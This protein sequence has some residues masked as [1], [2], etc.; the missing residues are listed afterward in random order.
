MRADLAAQPAAVRTNLRYLWVGNIPEKERAEFVAVLNGH[1]N[2]LS[3][4]IDLVPLTTVGRELLRVNLEDYAWDNS[5]WEK[6][7]DADPYYHT[8]IETEVITLWPGGVWPKDG[9][10]Y[11]AG[12]FRES[13]KVVT[14]AIAPWAGDTKA[15]AEVVNWTGSKVPVVRAD[16]FLA[17]TAIQ[18]GRAVGYYDFLGVKDQKGFEKLVGFD[19][20]LAKKREQRK[21]LVFSGITIQPRRVE[22]T[23]S[24]D[25]G[26]WRTFDSAKAV[27]KKNPLRILDD[28]GFE[29]DVTEQFAPLPNGLM[30]SYLGDSKGNRQDKAPDNIVQIPRLHVNLSCIECHFGR[31]KNEVGIKEIGH[32][33]IGKLSAVDYRK[34]VELKRKYL[35]DLGPSI[36]Q[37]RI[38]YAAAIKAATGMEPQAYAVAYQRWYS[39]YADAKVNLA[40]M[41]LDYGMERAALLKALDS[42]EQ[43]TGS[44]DAVLSIIQGGGS[45]PIEQYEELQPVIQLVI[46]GVVQP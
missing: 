26:L 42:Y 45:I 21:V 17:Q 12:S 1:C 27:D 31:V 24:V 37:D 32:T 2:G 28:D 7:A 41:A 33:P 13:R 30:A 19:A 43:R 22:R 9:K 39:N 14:T 35:R 5:T 34:Y 16:W 46:R 18:E 3:R 6:L 8:R 11:R 4:E 23:K 10:F 29:F 44:I 40:R 20:E 15:M 25:G 36:E 38:G